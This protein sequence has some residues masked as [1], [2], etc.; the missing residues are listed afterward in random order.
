MASNPSD[1]N[2]PADQ[3]SLRN[4]RAVKA[5][6][7]TPTSVMNANYGI[8]VDRGYAS[9]LP[10]T[11]VG[12]YSND[13]GHPPDF[14]TAPAAP[15]K[16]PPTPTFV[17]STATGVAPPHAAD[18]SALPAGVVRSSIPGVYLARGKDGSFMASNVMGADGAPDFGG[19]AAANA[20]AAGVTSLRRPGGTSFDPRLA[21]TDANGYTM[22][23]GAQGGTFNPNAGVVD[24]NGAASLPGAVRGPRAGFTYA[25]NSL[26]LN[27][28]DMI[29]AAGVNPEAAQKASAQLIAAIN[30]DP[31]SA[32]PE[33]A[34]ANRAALAQLQGNV[35]DVRREFFGGGNGGVLGMAGGVGGTGAVPAGVLSPKDALGLRMHQAELAERTA[36]D[37]RRLGIQQQQADRAARAEDR[38]A[39]QDFMTRYQQAEAN[40]NAPGAGDSILM[41]MTPQ[42]MSDKDFANWIS[43]D[44]KGQAWSAALLQ[45]L[46]KGAGNS[47]RFLEF[48]DNRHLG[49]NVNYGNMKLDKDGNFAGFFDADGAAGGSNEYPRTSAFGTDNYNETLLNSIP[50]R[51]WKVLQQQ[52]LHR[53]AL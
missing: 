47:L 5:A 7:L 44:P 30:N 37:N 41:Q 43:N 25:Q 52:G 50:K 8:G 48:G 4:N 35:Q 23:P 53:Q 24:A 49:Q 10:T 33:V 3:P 21:V 14:G 9:P 15:A 2:W 1:P 31:N 28:A 27:P 40:P 6:P 45:S 42:G 22:A 39:A 20:A 18:L 51:Y 11:P 12:L 38:Q 29:T 32:N 19:G 17:P 46:Q 26:H 34:A 13:T 36:R 16:P